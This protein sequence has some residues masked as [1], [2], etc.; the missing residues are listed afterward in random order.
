MLC[1][2]I[3]RRCPHLRENLIET[4]RQ[5]LPGSEVVGKSGIEVQSVQMFGVHTEGTL[6]RTHNLEGMYQLGT[7]ETREN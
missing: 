3:S 2:C 5:A 1:T 6:L 7:C 4:S